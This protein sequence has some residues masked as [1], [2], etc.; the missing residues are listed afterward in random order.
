MREISESRRHRIV[1]RRVTLG[2]RRSTGRC[3]I[4]RFETIDHNT[5]LLMSSLQSIIAFRP[6]RS[7]WQLRWSCA[8]DATAHPVAIAVSDP[9]YASA[10]L[11]IIPH[12]YSNTGLYCG[13]H[14]AGLTVIFPG[15]HS[16]SSL[17]LSLSLFSRQSL[18]FLRSCV[19]TPPPANFTPCLK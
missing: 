9:N 15:A 6:F 19:Q 3:W 1:C 4:L 5:E 10:V 17:S 8:V 16:L 14:E 18:S 11:S 12:S 7:P 2:R 13:R